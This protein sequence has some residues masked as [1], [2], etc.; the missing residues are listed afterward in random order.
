MAEGA[1]P[2]VTVITPPSDR[3]DL[4]SKTAASIA[5][6]S[7]PAVEHLILDGEYPTV[8]DAVNAGLATAR[9]D[10]V[11]VLHP[12][13]VLSPDGIS[14]L[15]SVIEDRPENGVV[16]CEVDVARGGQTE[17]GRVGVTGLS[18]REMVRSHACIRTNGM[19]FRRSLPDRIGAWDP[20]FPRLADCDFLFR[21]GLAGEVVFAAKP[22][23]VANAVG[24][25][26]ADGIA[27][28][29]EH[30]RLTERFFDR[31]DVPP[32]LRAV[33]DE[34]FLNAYIVAA[35][36]CGPDPDRVDAPW[37]I[38]RDALDRRPPGQPSDVPSRPA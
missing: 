29:D 16:C 25:Y 14:A 26:A 5:A 27:L 4:R 2:S 13:D 38:V 22:R 17:L 11:C 35:L 8:A 32:D 21:A 33:R 20:A 24:Q 36:S 3:E 18:H 6:Q 15:V 12:G 1:N 10:H 9:C 31:A 7:Y 34:A 28:A 30:V 37:R 19:L 23:V